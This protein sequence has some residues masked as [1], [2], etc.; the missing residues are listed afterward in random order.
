MYG[1]ETYSETCYSDSN[2]YIIYFN[3]K[4][5]KFNKC[6][7]VKKPETFQAGVTIAFN[8]NA[9]ITLIFNLSKKS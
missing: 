9:D 3:G 6:I 1:G 8:L 2:F 7:T 5:V 4:I